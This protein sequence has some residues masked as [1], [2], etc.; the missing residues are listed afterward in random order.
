MVSLLFVEESLR[1]E[2]D[3]EK[4]RKRVKRNE[5]QCINLLKSNLFVITL[6]QTCFN[7]EIPKNLFFLSLLL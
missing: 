7:Y 6:L 2:G 1:S 3:N 5:I 4:K